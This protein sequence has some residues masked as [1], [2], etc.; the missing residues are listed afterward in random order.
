MPGS[1]VKHAII[2][3]IQIFIQRTGE[4]INEQVRHVVIIFEAQRVPH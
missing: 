3:N 1:N 4:L 2:V